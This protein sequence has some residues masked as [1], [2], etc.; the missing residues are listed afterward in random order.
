M[1][2]EPKALPFIDRLVIEVAA[3]RKVTWQALIDVLTRSL[4]S[5]TSRRTAR[6]LGSSELRAS[7]PRPLSPGSTLPGFRVATADEPRALTL[8]GSHRF[9]R[10]EMIFDLSDLEEGR[11][12]LAVVTRAEF[13]GPIGSLYRTMVI[14]TGGHVIA[15]RRL[16]RSIGREAEARDRTP[17]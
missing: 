15:T 5:A 16:L 2:R 11:T 9:A 10:H 3:D 14:G 12:E 4:E 7:G 13:P 8:D 17:D 1:L 6:A